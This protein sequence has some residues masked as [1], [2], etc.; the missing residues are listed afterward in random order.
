[1][2]HVE[3][4]TDE[5]LMKNYV[6]DGEKQKKDGTFDDNVLDNQTQ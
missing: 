4:Q 3:C 2:T 1:M 6:P 5:A